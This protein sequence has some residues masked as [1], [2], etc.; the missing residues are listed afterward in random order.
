MR[1]ILISEHLPV[2]ATENKRC[3]LSRY[4]MMCTHP[5]VYTNPDVYTCTK[6]CGVNSKGCRRRKKGGEHVGDWAKWRDR[7]EERNGTGANWMR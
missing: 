3:T 5:D 2:C 4:T 1:V 7:R 6:M